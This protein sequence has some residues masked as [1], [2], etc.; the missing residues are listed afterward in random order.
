MNP[1]IALMPLASITVPVEGEGCPAVTDAIFP[2]RTT[3][4]PRSI[5]V[6]LG[7]MMR[8]LVMVRSWAFAVTPIVRT[9]RIEQIVRT[10]REITG[11]LRKTG[12]TG[13]NH[14]GGTG[15]TRSP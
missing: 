1:G 5:T 15:E 10:R 3:I 8:T 2:A 14:T 4:E 12:A 6:A 9:A 11:S 13:N 7:P